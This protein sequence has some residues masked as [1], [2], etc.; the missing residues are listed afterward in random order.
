METIRK[1][2]MDQFL[3]FVYLENTDR[4]RCGSIVTG[5]E[6]QHSLGNDQ[7]PKNLIAAQNVIE[8][9]QCDESYRKKR[10][11]KNKERNRQDNKEKDTKEPTKKDPLS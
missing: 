9:H 2:L 8:N 3:A 5:L 4:S 7:H 1:E 11:E 10:K 6:A